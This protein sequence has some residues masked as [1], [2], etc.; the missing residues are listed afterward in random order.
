[1]RT[2]VVGSL[3]QRSCAAFN[4]STTMR[5]DAALCYASGSQSGVHTMQKHWQ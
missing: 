1:M 2:L 4:L 3:R 5:S